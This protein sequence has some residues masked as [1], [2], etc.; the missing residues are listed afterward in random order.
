MPK[1]WNYTECLPEWND[2]FHFVRSP[3]NDYR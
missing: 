1:F 2:R 3:I